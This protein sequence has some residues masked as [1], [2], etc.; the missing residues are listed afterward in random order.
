[1]EELNNLKESLSDDYLDEIKDYYITIIK[2]LIVLKEVDIIK[3]N[4]V[5]FSKIVF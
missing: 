2:A 5:P 4:Y 1:M 3:L